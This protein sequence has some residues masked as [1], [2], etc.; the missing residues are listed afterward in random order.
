MSSKIR[1]LIVLLIPVLTMVLLNEYTRS[2]SP[3]KQLKRRGISV[4][5]TSQRT[6]EKCTWICHNDTDYCKGNHVKIL[7][8]YF[9]YTDPVYFEI[10]R[11][12]K[13]TGGYALANIIFLVLLIPLFIFLLLIRILGMQKEI[14]RLKSRS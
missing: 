9:E 11:F 6:A 7:Q 5:N 1:N 2:V 3:E 14:H 12:L 13:S 8:P 4:I 10:I